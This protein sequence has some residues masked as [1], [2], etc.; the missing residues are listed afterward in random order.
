MLKV[1]LFVSDNVQVTSIIIRAVTHPSGIARATR[2]AFD[3]SCQSSRSPRARTDVDL[4]RFSTPTTIC[5]S[6]EHDLLLASEH[7][8]IH[9]DVTRPY[10]KV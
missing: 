9:D 10:I 5:S 7:L 3:V 6:A 1:A 2:L 4:R 8:N